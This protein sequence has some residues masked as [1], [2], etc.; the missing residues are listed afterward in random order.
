MVRKSKRSLVHRPEVAAAHPKDA[1]ARP[2][3]VLTHPLFP[4]IVRQE[5]EPFA[6]VIVAKTPSALKK[7]L[8]R[9]DGLLC[10]LTDQITSRELDRAPRLRAKRERAERYPRCAAIFCFVNSGWQ[11]GNVIPICPIY[12]NQ[13]SK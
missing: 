9:A 5:L 7:A 3:I 8:S 11:I 1:P 10:L 6:N 2:T 4:E 13:T 12:K